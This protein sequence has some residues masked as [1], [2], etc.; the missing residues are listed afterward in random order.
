VRTERFRGALLAT[1]LI[2]SLTAPAIS[3]LQTTPASATPD[4]LV[5]HNPISINGNGGFSYPDPVNGG[6][7]G[8]ENDPYIIEN[9]DI[10]AENA[11]GIE[12]RNTTAHFVIRNCYSHGNRGHMGIFLDNVINGQIDNVTTENNGAGIR[13]RYSSNNNIM[14]SILLDDNLNIE[15]VSNSSNNIINNCT[16]YVYGGGIGIFSGSDNNH[17]YHNN[18]VNNGH[19]YDDGT[20][21]W[22]NGYPSGGNYW[23]DYT[24]VDENYGENQDI[25]GSDGIGDTPYDILGDNNRDRYPLV[26]TGTAVFSMENLYAVRLEK[27]LDLYQGSKLVV[28]FY[29][30][31]D[32]YENESVIENFVP[33]WHVEEIEKVPN[34]TLPWCVKSAV[35]KARLDLTYDNTEN[36]ISTIATFTVTRD[37]L[38]GRIMAIKGLWPYASPDE[39]DKLWKEITDIKALWPFAPS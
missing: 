34:P 10:S 27:N 13:L 28:K 8:T 3:L 35:K 21:Y 2:V 38:F 23:S 24:G 4:G 15:L 37:D 9:W 25:P 16:F 1:L 31:W 12:I 26:W 19:T 30:W 36:V 20:N 11:H 18:F 32:E 7:S 39:R 6:G 5:P 14:N 29:T 22:D 33:P 17:I